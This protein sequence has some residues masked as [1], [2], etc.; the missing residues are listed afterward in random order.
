MKK[1]L[2]NKVKEVKGNLLV[3]GVEDNQIIKE[4]EKNKQITICNSLDSDIVT[5]NKKKGRSKRVSIKKI[6]RVFKKKKVDYIICNVGQINKYMRYFIKDSVYIAKKE[7]ILYGNINDYDLDVLVKRYKRY[8]VTVEIKTYKKDFI[9]TIDVEKAKNNRLK[10]MF[11][12][13]KDTFSEISDFITEV[14]VN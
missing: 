6:R 2:L 11:Y 12:F 14:L 5:K 10:D 1:E 13:I 4:I 8:K 9:L 7:V 3:I